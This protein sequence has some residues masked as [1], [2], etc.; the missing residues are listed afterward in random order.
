MQNLQQM[1]QVHLSFLIL[2]TDRSPKAVNSIAL[3][4]PDVHDLLSCRFLAPSKSAV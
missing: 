2:G 1:Q 4:G 3:H